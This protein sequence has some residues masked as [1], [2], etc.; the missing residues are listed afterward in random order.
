[1]NRLD[2]RRTDLA[3]LN[4]RRLIDGPL[5]VFKLPVRVRSTLH[6]MWVPAEALAT[7]RYR[8]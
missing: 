5:A 6:G 8:A 3:I 1:V 2:E 4:A 7:G